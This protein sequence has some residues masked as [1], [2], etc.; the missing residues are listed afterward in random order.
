MSD[1]LNIDGAFLTDEHRMLRGQIARLV[2]EEIAPAADGWE[3][4]GR[5]P[6]AMFKRLGAL[7]MLGLAFPEA[8][9]GAGMDAAASVILNEE[10]ARSGYGGLTASLTVH[11]DMSALHLARVGTPEQK[12]RLLPGILSGDTICGLGVTEPRGGSDLT[13][14]ATTARREQDHYVLNGAKTFITNANIADIFF[15][16]VRTADEARGG[17]GFSLLMVERDTPGFSNGERFK[18]TGWHSSDTGELRF[19][20]ARVPVANLLGEAGKGFYY[21]MKGLD[22]ERLCAA[23]Q[24]LGLAQAAIDATLAWTRERPAYGRTLWD[25]QVIRQEMAKLVTELLAARALTYLV[26]LKAARGEP[27]QLEGAMLKAHVPELGNRILYKCVQYHGG[28]GYIQGAAVERIARD[29]RI[30]SIGGGA[31]EVMYDEVAKRL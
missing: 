31:A 2:R 27:I 3:T 23:G 18:K 5:V 29:I 6:A 30:L 7:G 21:M 12:A 11:T 20:D 4:D 24:V 14:I 16:V 10:L 22:H 19:D 25:L 17:S 28:G 13:R 1:I 26:A 9:G 8:D 15:V